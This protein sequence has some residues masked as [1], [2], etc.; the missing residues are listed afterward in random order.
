MAVK[1]INRLFYPIHLSPVSDSRNTF[2]CASEENIALE[3]DWG[4][5]INVHETVSEVADHADVLYLRQRPS[6]ELQRCHEGQQRE[7]HGGYVE[8]WLGSVRLHPFPHQG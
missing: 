7:N 2:A 1:F 6:P 3:I 5:T 8:D 4:S